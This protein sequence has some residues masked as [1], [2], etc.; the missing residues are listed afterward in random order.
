MTRP[1]QPV[2][3][4]GI[5]RPAKAGGVERLGDLLGQ[6]RLLRHPGMGAVEFEEQGGGRLH[7]VKL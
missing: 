1:P 6:L 5:R 2:T 7:L 3:L 4:L